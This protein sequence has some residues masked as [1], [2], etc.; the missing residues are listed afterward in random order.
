MYDGWHYETLDTFR[1]RE[2]E[3]PEIRKKDPE[4]Y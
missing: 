1:I 3:I 2:E 4:R